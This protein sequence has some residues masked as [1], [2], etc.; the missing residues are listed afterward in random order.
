MDTQVFTHKKL[1]KNEHHKEKYTD[2]NS[3]LSINVKGISPNISEW[4]WHP[5]F[6]KRRVEHTSSLQNVRKNHT[7]EKPHWTFRS[8][9]EKVQTAPA[10]H[11]LLLKAANM[12]HGSNVFFFKIFRGD[13]IPPFIGILYFMDFCKKPLRTWVETFIPFY[14][15]Q[16]EFKTRS[17][18]CKGMSWNSDKGYFGTCLMCVSMIIFYLSIKICTCHNYHVHYY[19]VYKVYIYIIHLK[20]LKISQKSRSLVPDFLWRWNFHTITKPKQNQLSDFDS[21]CDQFQWEAGTIEIY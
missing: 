9:W 2:F 17:H 11:Y 21:W 19:D 10:H 15:K 20:T 4:I 7:S 8:N 5:L 13:I 3:A 14:G 12:C 6:T 18:I 16:W 1:P